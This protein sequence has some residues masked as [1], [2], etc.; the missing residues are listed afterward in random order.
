[1]ENLPIWHNF[2]IGR[3]HVGFACAPSVLRRREVLLKVYLGRDDPINDV[4][5][6]NRG[7][8]CCEM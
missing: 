1:M 7:P 8:M 4:P 5:V 3:R 6:G 2:L